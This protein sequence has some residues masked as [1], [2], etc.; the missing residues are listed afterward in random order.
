MG[1]VQLW[2]GERTAPCVLLSTPVMAQA[3]QWV[4]SRDGDGSR[5]IQFNEFVEAYVMALNPADRP[6]LLQREIEAADRRQS[7]AQSAAGAKKRRLQDR[8][9]YVTVL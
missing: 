1:V 3:R 7:A 9:R 6:V 8:L 4:E 2:S 5:S